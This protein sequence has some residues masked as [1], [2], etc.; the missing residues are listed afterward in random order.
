MNDEKKIITKNRKARHDY[1][2][3]ESLE[4]GIVLVGSEVKSLREGRANLKDAYAV[5]REGEVFLIGMHIGPYSHTGYAQ[6]EPYRDRK[7]LL[8]RQE[9]KRLSRKVTIKG[10]TLVP[11]SV[12]LKGGLA[13]VELAVAK[14]KRTF[15]KKDAIA[16]RDHKRAM[17]KELKRRKIL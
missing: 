2:I 3:L 8:N 15:D 14:G 6:H 10:N 13:K 9:I 5:I 1:Y 11:L 17:A 12:Y 7:L 4:A 16:E